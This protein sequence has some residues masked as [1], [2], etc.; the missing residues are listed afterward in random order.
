MAVIVVDAEI[1]AGKSTLLELLQERLENVI[2]LTEP[3]DEWK[4][5]GI[6]DEFYNDI[7]GNA[8]KFQTYAF[9]TRIQ[10]CLK[11]FQG[12][13][14]VYIVERSIYSDKD[15]FV[16]MLYKAG[17]LTELEYNMYHQWWHLWEKVMPFK[18]SAFVYL[19]TPLELCLARIQ[20]RARGK[21]VN[22]DKEYHQQLR[23]QHLKFIEI[24]REE[25]F[26]VYELDGT[27]DYK[28]T[29][30]GKQEIVDCVKQILNNF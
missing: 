28:N 22:I 11:Y 23:D 18:P 27:I 16:Q 4:E 7:S 15:I 17:H 21:E 26:P 1:G 10:K 9:I 30:S 29:E 12:K 6:L 25:G 20:E 24:R 19:K 5:T 13:D 14:K 8:Y 2:I 3:V